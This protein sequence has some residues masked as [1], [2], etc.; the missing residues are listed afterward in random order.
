VV[1]R[2]VGDFDL[3]GLRGDEGGGEQKNES[4][5]AGNCTPRVGWG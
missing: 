4:R 1:V 3:G 5:H 2:L